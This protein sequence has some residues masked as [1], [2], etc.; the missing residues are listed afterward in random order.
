MKKATCSNSWTKITVFVT[1][2][3]NPRPT[4]RNNIF[5]HAITALQFLLKA[6]TLNTC[7]ALTL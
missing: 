1:K 3:L 5:Y 4:L 6:D 7:I 2:T